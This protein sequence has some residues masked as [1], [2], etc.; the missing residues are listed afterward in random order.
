MTGFFSRLLSR[1]EPHRP[2][3]TKVSRVAP[4]IAIAGT[5]KAVWSDRDT[6]ALTGIGYGRNAVAYRCIRMIAEAAASL[7][8]DVFSDSD[9]LENHPLR[10]LLLHPN[11][12]QTGGDLFEALYANLLCFGNAYIEV[13]SDGRTP[14]ELYALRPDRVRVVPGPDGWPEA[15][16]YAA[17]GHAVLLRNDGVEQPQ[18]LHLRMFDPLSDHYGMA[19]L[20]AA[21]VALDIHNSASS[22][23]KALLDNSARPSGALVYAAGGNNMTDEQFDRLK[24]EL[25]VTFSGALNAGRPILLEGGL[26]WKP[27]SLSPKDMDFM[28]AKSSAAREIALALGVPPLLLGLPGDNTFANYAEANRALWRQTVIPLAQRT[29]NAFAHWLTPAF[30]TGLRLELDLEKVEALASERDALWTR[31]EGASFLTTD[32][33]R[34]QAGF[35]PR[36]GADM[37]GKPATKAAKEAR[38]DRSPPFPTAPRAGA[39]AELTAKEFNPDQPRD[40]LGRWTDGGGEAADQSNIFDPLVHLASDITGFTRHGINRAIERGISPGAILDAVN[41]PIKIQPQ[42]NGTIR[43]IGGSAVV[44]LNADGQVVTLWRQ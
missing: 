7:R 37:S 39:R 27:L 26:D 8:Y 36:N 30:G 31:L 6:T 18:V 9:E 4:L 5:G 38:A 23:N 20:S 16:E 28:E 33:K 43:Y 10:Q 3:E 35:K 24:E 44:V 15:Y 13:V 2:Q 22:W 29:L 19:P 41:N 11:P 42:S 12:R 34:E 32:D 21:Q 25:D 17:G 1:A 14:R 40:D